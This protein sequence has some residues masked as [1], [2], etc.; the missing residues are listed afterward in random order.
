MNK[1]NA[2]R[3]TDDAS[4]AF[5]E[6]LLRLAPGYYLGDLHRHTYMTGKGLI[7]EAG[8]AY[9]EGLT[10][11]EHT[12]EAVESARHRK[13][14]M[15]SFLDLG[16]TKEMIHGTRSS[17]ES[18]CQNWI[19][20]VRM[21]HPA[22]GYFKFCY[23]PSGKVDY[24]S[25]FRGD[26]ASSHVGI[27]DINSYPAPSFSWLHAP[28]E[29]SVADDSVTKTPSSTDD[30]GI[31]DENV[32]EDDKSNEVVE[33]VEATDDIHQ[34]YLAALRSPVDTKPFASLVYKPPQ[35]RGSHDTSQ[36]R[37]Q[38]DPA[39]FSASAS[40]Q[41][42]ASQG[43]RSEGDSQWQRIVNEGR[44]TFTGSAYKPHRRSHVLASLPTGSAR[45][46]TKGTHSRSLS[47]QSTYKATGQGTKSIR[48]LADNLN[49]SVFVRQLPE[50]VHCKEIFEVIT[51]GSVVSVHISEPIPG[52]PFSA[53]N[54]TF[55]YPE[56]AA[57]FMALVNSPVGTQIRDHHLA[58]VYNRHGM[59]KHADEHQSRV[60]N[61]HG[62]YELMTKDFWR[63]YFGTV[64]RYYL[65]HVVYLPFDPK[66]KVT[67]SMEFHFARI[68]AQAQSILL[69]IIHDPQFGGKVSC[70]YGTDPCGRDWDALPPQ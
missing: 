6:E 58:A 25:F 38:S 51:T 48:D 37:S 55:K 33:V 14:L 20:S 69:A 31:N 53:A 11:E 52:C 3:S 44:K 21:S 23:S 32:V 10:G 43:N 17:F 39:I 19:S 63:R 2:F 8:N 27:S 1:M 59:I 26:H 29:V 50:D 64:T 68:E 13:P 66:N 16:L 56:G 24:E 49:C 36:S 5:K 60:I 22:F 57:R 54:I 41:G 65:D 34:P 7:A 28:P 70:K 67:R 61:I 30:Q 47:T 9:Q 42:R 4:L 62:P 45:S 35:K 15:K 18:S 46:M 12:A 40:S